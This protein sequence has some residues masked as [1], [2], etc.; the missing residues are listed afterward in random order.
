MNKTPETILPYGDGDRKRNQVESMFDTIADQ[1]D[2]LNH[3]M[4]FQQDKRWRKKAIL[5]LKPDA[6][7]VMLDIA[8]GTGDFALE[9]YKRLK[10]DHIIGADL[11]EGMMKVAEE[12]VRKAG[13]EAYLS[14]EVQDCTAL[15]FKDN[16][17]DAVTIA[18][19]VRN[20]EN[21][22]KGISEMYRVLKPGGRM[23]IIELSRPEK[24]PMKQLFNIYSSVV[25]PLAGKLFSKDN[26]AYE[27]LPAS[28]KVVPQSTEMVRIMKEQGFAQAAFT[29]YTFGV[30]TNYS[31][32]KP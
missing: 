32:L 8:T 14:F 17:F 25:L 15:T 10:P 9:A 28:I 26:L 27:Y 7:K 13:L 21:I 24:F 22:A 4:S 5:S 23:V 30:C 16:T 11:S 3:F 6:P 2:F 12:K 29:P 20:F 31:G 1:Y 19:G 18:F